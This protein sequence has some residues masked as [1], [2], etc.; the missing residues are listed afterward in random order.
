MQQ[1]NQIREEVRK[2]WWRWFEKPSPET[3]KKYLEAL[4]KEEKQTRTYHIET[5]K[6]E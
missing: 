3:Y 2:A 1:E 6:F 4:A 5:G